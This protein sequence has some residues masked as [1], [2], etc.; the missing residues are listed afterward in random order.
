MAFCTMQFHGSSLNKKSSMNLLI[1]ETPGPWPV[2]VLLHGLSDDHT[3]WCRRTSLERYLD[4]TNLLV[5]MPDGHRNWYVNDPRNGGLAYED[6]IVQDVIGFV[7]RTFDTVADRSARAVAGLSMGG[8]GAIMLGLKHP[9]LFSAA[10][11]HSSAVDFVHG[12][13]RKRDIYQEMVAALSAE[14]YDV[15]KLAE[16]AVESGRAP[17]LRLDC[18]VDDFLIEANRR[19]HAHLESIAL[20]HEYAEYP[21][22]HDWAYW[23]EHI[24]ES[25]SFVEANLPAMRT[26]G[27]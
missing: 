24:Q 20:A 25:L 22:A 7:D 18:G 9:E 11:G 4:G 12:D 5:V 27:D 16:A 3:I 26:G 15:Y 13:G 14:Q 17:A 2:L 23:D 6:H 8:Y 1:P 19:F 21:G 10:C